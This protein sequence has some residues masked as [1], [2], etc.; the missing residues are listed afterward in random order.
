MQARTIQP[1]SDGLHSLPEGTMAIRN[2]ILTML[3]RPQTMPYIN[4]LFLQRPNMP[5][6]VPAPISAPLLM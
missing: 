6:P 3:Q 2:N 5:G 4:P 1:P